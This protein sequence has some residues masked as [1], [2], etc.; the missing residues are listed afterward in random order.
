MSDAVQQLRDA[1]DGIR[2]ELAKHHDRPELVMDTDGHYIL[3]PAL[4]ALVIA[5]AKAQAALTISPGQTLVVGLAADVDRQT[6]DALADHVAAA[7]CGFRVL[8]IVGAQQLAVADR[9]AEEG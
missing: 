8:F 5:E 6:I 7:D 3:L 1:V 2:A 4:V 9:P